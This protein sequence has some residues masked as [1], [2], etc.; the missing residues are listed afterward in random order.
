[1]P[2]A[3]RRLPIAA[4][5]ILSLLVLAGRGESRTRDQAILRVGTTYYVDTL[6]P[7]VGIETNDTTAYEMVYPQL[8]Q[9]GP[10]VKIAGDWASS[11]T[12]SRDGLVW[13]FHL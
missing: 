4:L 9:Y 1:M 8:V 5:A 2:T 6:N 11:W 7:F 12:H 13:T 3:A 10:G